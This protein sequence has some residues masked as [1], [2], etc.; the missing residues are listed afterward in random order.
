[1]EATF[2]KTTTMFAGG[3]RQDRTKWP[4]KLN[5]TYFHVDVKEGRVQRLDWDAMLNVFCHIY[6]FWVALTY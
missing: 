6:I 5:S 2:L 4:P 1:M 3:Q